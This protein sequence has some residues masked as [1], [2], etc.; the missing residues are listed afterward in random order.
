MGRRI[1]CLAPSVAGGLMVGGL[2]IAA[3]IRSRDLRSISCESLYHTWTFVLVSLFVVA[4]AGTLATMAVVSFLIG[5]KVE[6]RRRFRLLPFLL[7]ARLYSARE[8]RGH[9]LRFLLPLCFLFFVMPGVSAWGMY[10]LTSVGQDSVC[11][12]ALT[13]DRLCQQRALICELTTLH[14]LTLI[15]TMLGLVPLGAILF[16]VAFAGLLMPC[17]ML[18][19]WWKEKTEARLEEENFTLLSS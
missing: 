9:A 10:I 7:S 6:Q 18:E 4:V 19:V 17:V 15:Y 3:L 16:F 2:T 1:V 5:W 8:R 14:G 11:E 13:G 12:E